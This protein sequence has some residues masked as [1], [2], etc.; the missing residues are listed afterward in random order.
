LYKIL[1]FLVQIRI[2]FANIFTSELYLQIKFTELNYFFENSEEAM[3][4]D[5]IL[6]LLAHWQEF[7]AVEESDDLA[8]F[9][10]WLSRRATVNH[11]SATFQHNN[12]RA[13][14]PQSGGDADGSKECDGEF[15]AE[16]SS[17]GQELLGITR[18]I[19]SDATSPE[20]TLVIADSDGDGIEPPS[21]KSLTDAEREEIMHYYRYLPLDAKIMAQV[22]RINRFVSFYIK[23]AFHDLTLNSAQE[24]GVLACVEGVS[25]L[26][27]TEVIHYNLLEKTTGTELMKRF[28]KI[29]FIEEF[30]D[31]N[32]KRSKR[33]RIT[34][35][36]REEFKKA[37]LRLYE[38]SRVVGGNLENHEKQDLANALDKL[39]DFHSTIYFEQGTSTIAE[40]VERNI[41]ETP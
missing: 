2:T 17:F 24:F 9:A 27:K 14:Q 23:K 13:H 21:L 18:Q 10:V 39:N 4:Y 36:G 32:D 11:H 19:I 16:G 20:Q 40:I 30:D 29:G 28:I 15:N 3:K 33:V 8:R 25:S 26:T 22:S 12:H 38:A 7:E 34:E 5:R 6:G 37:I 1:Y 31:E 41:L 35:R